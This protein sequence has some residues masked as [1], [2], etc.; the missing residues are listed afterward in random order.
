MAAISVGGGAPALAPR[1]PNCCAATA[2]VPAERPAFPRVP[3]TISWGTGNFLVLG[4][5]S[6]GFPVNVVA[7]PQHRH[8]HSPRLPGDSALGRPDS[9]PA[10]GCCSCN[11]EP[12]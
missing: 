9:P 8:H 7:T 11:A 10:T 2:T 5:I 6:A 4:A 1:L 12:S 3:T